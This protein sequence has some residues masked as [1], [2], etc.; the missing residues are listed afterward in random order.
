MGCSK[1]VVGLVVPKGYSFNLDG[2]TIYLSVAVL[3][4]SQI[5][6]VDLTAA[7]I[8]IV[9]G[10]LMINSKGAAGVIG[11]GFI[12]LASTISGI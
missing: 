12:V 5:F 8:F 3:F 9:I 6:N 10:I 7:Q 11:S 4:L 2:T 1:A